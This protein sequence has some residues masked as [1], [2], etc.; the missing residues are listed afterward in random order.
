MEYLLSS[1]YLQV[2][3]CY[4]ALTSS[5]LTINQCIQLTNRVC[6]SSQ[7]SFITA[8]VI[9]TVDGTQFPGV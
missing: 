7:A 2:T 4:C 5:N 1:F 6:T 9:K 8:E 3:A